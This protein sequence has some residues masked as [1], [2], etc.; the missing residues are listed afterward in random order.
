MIH[1]FLVIFQ[2]HFRLNLKECL[3]NQTDDI[4]NIFFRNHFY[5]CMHITQRK[6]N[7]STRNSAVRMC[8]CICI[9]TRH[10]ACSCSLKRNFPSFRCFNNQL[11]YRVM[12]AWC[13]K[14]QPDRHHIFGRPLFSFRS[15]A[16]LYRG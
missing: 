9:G 3:I 15:W 6:G 11:S 12:N 8:K 14:K 10:S 13:K 5:S 2:L 16:W 7:Q 1:Y 4:S